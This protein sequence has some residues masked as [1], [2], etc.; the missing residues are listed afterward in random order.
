MGLSHIAKDQQATASIAADCTQLIDEQVSA[1]SGLSGLAF[2]AAYGVVKG[3]GGDYI[4]GA[5]G[6]LLP[7]TLSA[8][9]PL[10][11]EGTQGGDP[12]AHLIQNSDR[13][14]DAILSATDARIER[15]SNKLICSSY[16]KFRSSVK[17]DIVAAVPGFA[18]ILGKHANA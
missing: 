13:T 16:N 17:G 11:N 15:A 5:L 1:K 8:L 14:A 2:K 10:W 7:E 12:V 6:R 4:P 9:D 18:Q 3:L